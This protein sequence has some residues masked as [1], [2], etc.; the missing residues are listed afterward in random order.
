M[1]LVFCFIALAALTVRA[2]SPAV[3]KYLNAAIT[4][5][6]NL[7]YE[8]ALQQVKRAKAHAAGPDDEA[9]IALFE[10][11]VLADMG[12]EERA[13]TAFKTGYGLNLEAKLPVEVSPKVQALADRARDNVRK[14]LAPRLEAEHLE[15][16]KAAR[17]EAEAQARAEAARVEGERLA[18]Q[19]REE[20]AARQA[21]PVA[22]GVTKVGPSSA[23]RYA[24]LPL[25][26][27]AVSGGVALGLWADAGT[28]YAA[29][30]NGTAPP[31]QALAFRDGGRLEATLGAVLAGV[32][33]AGAVAAVLMFALGGEGGPAVAVAPTPGGAFAAVSFSFDLGV[34]R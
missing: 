15:A 9:R 16:E 7:D 17:A 29:L 22:P 24:W 19:R 4:L 28:K 8:K 10:G 23:R 30:V 31:E 5:Y 20:E 33:G 2:Q 25:A 13:L 27:G 1:R 14:L 12:K 26:V 34:G 32:A 6:E 18:A 11:V 3:R 21:S